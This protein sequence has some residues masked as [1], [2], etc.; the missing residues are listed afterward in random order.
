MLECKYSTEGSDAMN[1]QILQELV[2]VKRSGQRVSFNGLKIAVAIKKAF[3]SVTT[4]YDEKKVNKVYEDTLQYIINNYQ[5]RKTIN[6]E[7]IQDII[8]NILKQDKYLNIYESFSEYRIRRAESRKAFSI[9]QQHKFVKA[10]EKIGTI[11]SE[12]GKPNEL[13][14]KFGK[15][16][17]D[18]Y[19]KSYILDNKYVRA[20]EEGKIYI[21]NFAYFNLGYLSHTHLKL[22]SVLNQDNCFF[23]L[24][25]LLIKSKKEVNG[26]IAID[27]I[28]NNLSEYVL[29][30][31]KETFKTILHSY[32][33]VTGFKPFINYRKID[34]MINKETD[35]SDDLEKYNTMFVNDHTFIIL[36][37]AYQDTINLVENFL[38][39]NINK[40]LLTLNNNHEINNKY[41]LSLGNSNST[42]SNMINK[43]IINQV[44]ELDYL[45]NVTLIYKI[46]SNISDDNLDT[47]SKLIL[48]KKNIKLSLTTNNSVEYF[49]NGIRIF[50]N[51][52]SNNVS[53][54]RSNICST[55]INMARLGLKHRKL[56][57]NFYK[58]LDELLELTKNQ[59]L[60]VFETIGD[61][62]KDNYHTLFNNNILDDE[63]LEN[64][65]TIRKVIKNGTLNI[66]LI[67][68][69]ECAYIIDCDNLRE[70]ELKILKYLNK[71][72]DEITNTNKLNFTLSAINDNYASKKLIDLDKTV[73]G[74]IDDVTK[75]ER[76]E[77]INCIKYSNCDNEYLVT[78]SKIQS[79]LTG[80]NILN[81]NIT[82]NLSEK[83]ISELIKKLI[84][85]KVYFISIKLEEKK[86]DN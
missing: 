5:D 9:K 73:F 52:N 37:N 65:G 13:L 17:S 74:I 19:I 20:Y 60:F 43:T 42:T 75:K 16:I 25:N 80:G 12:N 21:D 69:K 59:L 83:N 58:E 28:D 79:L 54:G 1:N 55:T 36:K 23:D 81:I 7:D 56:D 64:G 29:N 41:S 34:E 71:K 49:S 51:Y 57:N 31:Y 61:K 3:D 18:E 32:L 84:E 30:Y 82:N 78:T 4:E 35:I 40:L 22:N 11:N 63:K 85:A 38:T 24:L 66:N 77:C 67:G 8:E 39:K 33:K 27:S 62:T 50:E 86:N 2:V 70:T 15:T 10:I 14:Y 76:Y 68:L 6:V 45:E 46:D 53:T 26:E 47:I 72:V 48:S 44:S